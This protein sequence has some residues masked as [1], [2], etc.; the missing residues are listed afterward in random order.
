MKNIF[1]T[2]IPCLALTVGLASCYDE[3]DDKAVIDAQ[4]ALANTPSVTI[5]SATALDFSSASVSASLSEVEGVVEVGFYVATSAD[6]SNSKTYVLD[7]VN[8]TFEKTLAGLAEKSTY[9]VKAYAYLGDGRLVF[10][11]ATSVATPQAPPLTTELLSGK[12]YTATVND[13]WSEAYTFEVTLMA[14]ASDE[15]KIY[16]QNLDP[17][18]AS[19]GYVAEVGCNI[20]E[21]VLDTEK[22]I[23]TVPASQLIGY[24]ELVLAALDSDD[25][26]AAEDNENY[27]K[28]DLIIK[29]V[30][31]GASLQ[32]VNAFGIYDAAQ[33]GWWTLY[34]GGF[35]LNVK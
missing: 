4:Y 19:Y 10:S 33:G 11:E 25:P 35:T 16:I 28:S 3:M 24:G 1:K 2:L 7:G 14:D 34:Y 9:H 22:E 12:T 31:K 23:I 30:G 17:Y 18:F 27:G 6:F 26:D 20:F 15:N 8:S 21:G 29:V 5:A 32:F 13:Y